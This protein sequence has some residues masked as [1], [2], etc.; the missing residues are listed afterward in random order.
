MIE[1]SIRSYIIILQIP[2]SLSIHVN[3]RLVYSEDEINQNEVEGKN[4]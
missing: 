2:F 4:L 1:I 3:P